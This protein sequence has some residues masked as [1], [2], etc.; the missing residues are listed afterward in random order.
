MGTFNNFNKT[1]HPLQRDED[2]GEGWH[3][4]E[5]DVSVNHIP[6]GSRIMLRIVD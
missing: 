5:I 1:S 3:F 2:C 6:N 4:I